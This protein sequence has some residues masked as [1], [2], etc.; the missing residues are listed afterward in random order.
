M[1]Y[2]WVTFIWRV[3]FVMWPSSIKVQ[4]ITCTSL[5]ES[6]SFG[7]EAI[8]QMGEADNWVC[9][10]LG[11]VGRQ[12]HSRMLSSSEGAPPGPHWNCPR[13][14]STGDSRCQLSHWRCAVLELAGRSL[15]QGGESQLNFEK[16]ATH[17]TNDKRFTPKICSIVERNLF[18]APRDDSDG[19]M[20]D[21][22]HFPAQCS[23][24]YNQ[25]SGLKDFKTQLCQDHCHKVRISVGKQWHV[26]HK[27]TAVIADNLLQREKKSADNQIWS[28]R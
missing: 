23:F 4:Q 18:T 20:L 21:E 27:P 7:T 10:K 8:I 13:S 6:L 26:G 25:V 9:E 5:P 19:S 12:P 11:P 2:Y 28:E 22:V 24:T 14:G 15:N 16:L 1:T 3:F 17:Q